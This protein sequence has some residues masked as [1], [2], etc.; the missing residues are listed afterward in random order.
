MKVNSEAQVVTPRLYRNEQT[1]RAERTDITTAADSSTEVEEPAVVLDLSRVAQNATAAANNAEKLK[2]GINIKKLD[3]DEEE[4]QSKK[5]DKKESNLQDSSA[6]LM[7]KLSSA[8]SKTEVQQVMGEA[9]KNLGEALSAAASGDPEAIE[10]VNKLNS[11]MT[12]VY[13][14]IKD[15]EEEPDANVR[16]KRVDDAVAAAAAGKSNKDKED[17]GIPG[18][19]KIDFDAAVRAL[20]RMTKSAA[21]ATAATAAKIPVSTGA[22]EGIAGSASIT[23]NTSTE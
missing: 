13:R 3:E 10:I 14:K 5:A 8:R 6:K 19:A 17:K 4:K 16:K 2:N 15:I 22:S 9:Q 7:K 20:D 18:A 12:R 11:L 1:L 23:D 21:R